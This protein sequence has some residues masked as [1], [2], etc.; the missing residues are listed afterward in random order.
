VVARHRWLYIPD[1]E[2]T[3]GWRSHDAMHGEAGR[4][5][6]AIGTGS[7]GPLVDEDDD[8]SRRGRR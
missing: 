6:D 1:L 2:A 5:A 3:T 4:L 8:G 7:I